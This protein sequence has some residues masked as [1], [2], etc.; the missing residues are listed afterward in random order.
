MHE[1]SSLSA[2]AQRARAELEKAVAEAMEGANATLAE[3]KLLFEK[4]VAVIKGAHD[5]VKAEG[6]KIIRLI[7]QRMVDADAAI[8]AKM[9]AEML[10]LREN[11]GVAGDVFARMRSN[12]AV[13][14]R[15]VDSEKCSDI[16]AFRFAPV[17]EFVI[18]LL[19]ASVGQGMELDDDE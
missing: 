14:R 13:A 8:D 5:V 10:R 7:E 16:E 15:V 6:G 11:K 4:C 1:F 12:A 17:S 3:T 9:A 2:A 18:Q 19:I